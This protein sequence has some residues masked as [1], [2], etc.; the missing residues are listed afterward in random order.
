MV[1]LTVARLVIDISKKLSEKLSLF[2]VLSNIIKQDDR[3]MYSY[4]LEVLFSTVINFLVLYLI[5]TLFGRVWETTLFI[6]GFIPLRALAGGYH[7]KTHF[8]CTLILLLAYTLFLT[9]THLILPKQYFYINITFV[10]VS[11]ICVWLL[12]PVED[13]NK[14]ISSNEKKHY[15]FRSRLVI[16]LYA[17]VVIAGTSLFQHKIDFVCVSFGL[18]SASLSL[19]AAYIKS[20]RKIPIWY[21]KNNIG[22]RVE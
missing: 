17:G 1:V 10:S 11:V 14:P 3:E 13:K 7:A 2:F 4:S 20:N 19:V 12:S 16:L 6:I 5:A 8:R 21:S 18:L 22:R 9:T 15:R